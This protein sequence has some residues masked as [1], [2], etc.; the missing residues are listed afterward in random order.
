MK[1]LSSFWL[2]FW[3]IVSALV[4]VHL[5]VFD[6]LILHAPAILQVQFTPDDGYYY[7][8]LAR[9]FVR[10]GQWTFDGGL[11]LT[12][13][14]H[15]MQAYLLVGLYKLLQP[16]SANFVTLALGLGAL[17][18]IL[19]AIIVWWICWREQDIFFLIV[20]TIL[21]SAKSFLFDSVSI[22]E[23]PLVIL[24]SG[25][26]CFYFY[27]FTTSKNLLIPFALGLLGS[28]ARSDFGL[29]PFCI[30]VSALFIERKQESKPFTRATLFGFIG[31]GLGIGLIFIHNFI[32]TGTLIQS[33]ALMKSYW[34]NFGNQSFYSAADLIFQTLG[35]DLGFADFQRSIFL[36]SLLLIS[37]P[38]IVIILAKLSGKN[39]LSL[40]DFKLSKDQPAHEKILVLASAICIVG[41]LLFYSRDGAI[42]RWYTANFIWPIFILLVAGAR[43]LNQRLLKEELFA[44]IWLSIFALATLGVQLFSLYPL[45]SQSAP[46]PHHQFMLEAGESL[47]QNPPDAY[48]GA[49][50]SGVLG[51]YQGGTRVVNLDGLV[52]NDIYPYAVS[53]NLP[54]YLQAKNIHY[55]LDFQNMLYPPFTQRGGYDNPDFLSHLVPLKT[56][57]QG[58]FIEFK[59]LRLYRIDS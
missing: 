39:H 17:I 6:V 41:Y 3:K 55:I 58:Q 22:T 30:F 12:S 40:A 53:H 32:T 16:T 38:L 25:L 31:A 7:L 13:G 23:W 54:A 11:S 43:Y 26:Y 27:R 24:I 1:R 4:L 34:A 10:F 48:V 28:L 51:Y 47:A 5:I 19:A 33:S 21:V 59:F 37:G 29:L 35:M 56:F 9:N 44:P 15:L 36:L 42:Q 52:N 20:F 46:W 14:F 50:N 18:T 49:W 2:P 57:D 8:T 45:S